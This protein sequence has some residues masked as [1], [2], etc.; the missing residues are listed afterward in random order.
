MMCLV[1]VLLLV[2]GCA[3]PSH[4][5]FYQTTVFGLDVAVSPE[6]KNV[7]VVAGYDR[8]TEAV[9][10]TSEIETSPG[11]KRNEA[12]SVVGRTKID[13]AWLGPQKITDN[14]ATGR[15]AQNV[16]RHPEAIANLLNGS[17]D[18]K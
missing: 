1:F 12:L 14:F 17:K 5:F 3:N 15:A 4:L 13:A 10:P 9:I 7:K 6:T 8:Q 18:P 16:A 2:S 11:Q